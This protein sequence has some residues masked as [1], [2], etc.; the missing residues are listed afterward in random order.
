V[1]QLRFF[2]KPVIEATRGAAPRQ[3]KRDPVA[4]AY[5]EGS[6]A[7]VKLSG[8]ARIALLVSDEKKREDGVG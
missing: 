1:G 2:K 7:G 3:G 6:I 4:I 8:V 5:K